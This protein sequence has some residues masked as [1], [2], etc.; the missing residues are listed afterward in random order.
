VNNNAVPSTPT[1]VHPQDKPSVKARSTPPPPYEPA[2]PTPMPALPAQAH[3]DHYR[4]TTFTSSGP[5]PTFDY[6]YN[7]SQ[8]QPRPPQPTRSYSNVT[9]HVPAHNPT[10]TYNA[11][12]TTF[13]NHPQYR[14]PYTCLGCLTAFFCPELPIILNFCRGSFGS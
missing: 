12:P 2:A 1:T 5:V 8:N 4:R 13:P 14:S 7:A 11:S 9:P 6:N 3:P 10:S